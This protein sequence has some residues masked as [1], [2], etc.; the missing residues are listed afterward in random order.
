MK[1]ELYV[2]RAS[3]VHALHPATKI[4]LLAAFLVGP[5]LSQRPSVQLAAFALALAAALGGRVLRDVLRPWKLIMFI[6][7]ITLVIW[8]LSN[9][10]REGYAT[11]FRNSVSY[12]V[13]VTAV[14]L[15]G[16]LYL[17]VTRIEETI[18]GLEDLRVPYRLAFSLG[19]AFRLVPLFLQSAA[20]ILEAQRARGLDIRRGPLGKRLRRF[21]PILIPIFMTSLRTADG[22]AIALEARGF[23]AP[24]PRTRARRYRF[25]AAD[26]AALALGAGFLA[27]CLALRAG[28]YTMIP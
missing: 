22:M 16:L 18:H 15:F 23:G 12:A 25:G 21:V 9:G 6:F 19:L 27:A 28:R 7:V 3:A 11:S 14:F 4:L 5:F 1:I 26:I 13:R 20:S 8:G 17:A 2:P 24:G 10:S